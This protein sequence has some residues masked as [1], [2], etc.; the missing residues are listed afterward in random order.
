M[1]SFTLRVNA[2][3]R[4][5]RFTRDNINRIMPIVLDNKIKSA[6]VI[7]AEI[8]INGQIEGNFAPRSR[9]MTFRWY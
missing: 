5:S 2:A 3:D 8:G 9:P 7:R 6:P 1:V 4:F